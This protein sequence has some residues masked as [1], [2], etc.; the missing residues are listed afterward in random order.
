MIAACAMKHVRGGSRTHVH[1]DTAAGRLAHRHAGAQG[2]LPGA[3]RRDPGPGGACRG[4]TSQ[5]I[6]SGLR[7]ISSS[8]SKYVIRTS[9][10][11][12]EVTAENTVRA[13]KDLSTVECAARSIR[14]VDPKVRPIF[15]WL[16]DRIRGHVFL[17]M[18]AYYIE[19]HMRE[20]LS[21]RLFDD[22]ELDEAE[23]T[24]AS[25]EL[26]PL[27]VRRPLGP[28]TR[29]RQ[30]RMDCRSTGSDRCSR[31]WQ[32]WRNNASECTG[33]SRSEFYE[34]THASPFREPR[35]LGRRVRGRT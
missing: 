18:I 34:L 2:V 21:S 24:R 26:N 8:A 5:W 28:R 9:V 33:E 15:H 17:C 22:H 13:Y 6:R 29:V 12:E 32:L 1:L 16:D 7:L 14:T 31:I 3:P 20:R 27:L 25:I 30:P 10:K 23:K 4:R 19:W 35:V 11:P